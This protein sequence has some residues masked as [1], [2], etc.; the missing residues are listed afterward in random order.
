VPASTIDPARVGTYSVSAWGVPIGTYRIAQ[1]GSTPTI[2]AGAQEAL[3][4]ARVDAEHYLSS[5]GELLDLSGPAPTY[6]SIRLDARLDV[7]TSLRP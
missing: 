5:T 6:A 2:Q 1:Q 3:R 4:L 7:P